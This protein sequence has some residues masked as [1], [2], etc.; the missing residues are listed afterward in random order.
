MTRRLVPTTKEVIVNWN[1][2]YRHQEPA[3]AAPLSLRPRDAAAAIGVS[4]S[5]LER[6]VRSGE[7]DSVLIG[8]CRVF[9]IETLK[10]Y[11][12]SRRQPAKGGCRE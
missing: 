1:G 7:I 8:R 11:L 5:T 2:F 10:A 3:S 4:V 9:E 12:Q 6:L